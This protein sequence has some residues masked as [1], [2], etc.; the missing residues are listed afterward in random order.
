MHLVFQMK[1]GNIR[2]NRNVNCTTF[3][4]YKNKDIKITAETHFVLLLLGETRQFMLYIFT[5]K[6]IID[7]RELVLRSLKVAQVNVFSTTIYRFLV[8]LEGV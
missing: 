7:A 1:L 5:H 4:N 8:Y 2:I 3:S 6:P